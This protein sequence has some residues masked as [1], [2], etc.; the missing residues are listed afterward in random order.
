MTTQTEARNI[1]LKTFK[2]GFEKLQGPNPIPWTHDNLTSDTSG[3]RIWVVVAINQTAS[4]QRTLGQPGNRRFRREGVL[5]AT[6]RVKPGTGMNDA[7]ILAEGI[8]NIFEGRSIRGINPIGGVL[9]QE[10]GRDIA[11]YRILVSFPHWYEERG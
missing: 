11:G 1:L 10:E 4:I 5:N 8:R 7:M 2:D 3:S 9:V 6:I